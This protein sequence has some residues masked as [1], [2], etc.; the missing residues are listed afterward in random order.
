VRSDVIDVLSLV[1]RGRFFSAPWV[2]PDGAYDFGEHQAMPIKWGDTERDRVA[3]AVYDAQ[4][5]Q[6]REQIDKLTFDPEEIEDLARR[7]QTESQTAQVLIFYSYLDDRI[8]QLIQLHLRMNQSKSE[9][10][11][12]FGV[13][14]PLSTFNNRVLIA[15]HLG[16]LSDDIRAKLDAFRKIRNE[17]A[18]RAFKVTIDDPSL[19]PYLTTLDFAL[20]AMMDKSNIEKGPLFDCL[21]CQLVMLAI[22]TFQELIVL[23]AANAMHVMPGD[24]ASTFDDAPALLRKMNL[25][26]SGA[27]ILAAGLDVNEKITFRQ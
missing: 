22:Q 20:S 7:L 21:L 19:K 3:K 18:H 12:L 1:E 15:Y 11:R 10:D 17:F 24:V 6:A 27:L 2:S 23:P 8:Q 5:K 25:T 9:T 4:V 26:M 14:G 16:W 13:N